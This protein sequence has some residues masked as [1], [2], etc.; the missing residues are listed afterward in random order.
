MDNSIPEVYQGKLIFYSMFN[1]DNVLF[2]RSKIVLNNS[3][4]LKGA[5]SAYLLIP[6]EHKFFSLKEYYEIN[7][8]IP[9]PWV[10]L[11]TPIKESEFSILKGSNTIGK[12]IFDSK[13][14]LWEED[15]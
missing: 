6:E 11:E 8:I 15:I 9:F 14:G 7:I 13:N 3:Y 1:T 12:F 4:Y 5:I 10:L 2:N